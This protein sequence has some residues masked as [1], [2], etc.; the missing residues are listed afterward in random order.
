[1]EALEI[2]QIIRREIRAMWARTAVEALIQDVRLSLRIL[3]KHPG[4]TATVLSTAALGISCTTTIFTF[5]D[6]LLLRALPVRQPQQLVAIGTPGRNLNLNPT[7]FSQPFYRYLKGSS[8]TFSDLAATSIAVSSGVT[9]ENE[10]VTERIRIELVSGNYFQVLGIQPAMGRFFQPAEDATPNANPVVVVSHSFWEKHFGSSPQA[11]GRTLSL[12]GH[13]FTIVG[14]SGPRFFGTRPGF[15]P[16]AWA[17][18]MMVGQLGSARIR[19]DQ[20][21]QNYV[22]LF[23]RLPEKM[24]LESADAA[25]NSAFQQWLDSQQ[26]VR[27]QDSNSTLPA[28]AL[29]PMPRGLSLL[30]GQ[31]SE[32]LVI[33]MSS[34]VLL[35]L[36]SCAN[37]ATLLLAHATSRSREIAVRLS[38]GAGR[39]RI[40]RQM[41]TESIL[42]SILGG[43][44][45]WVASV[46]LGRTLLAF[47][48]GKV[49][50]LEFSPN[51]TIFLFAMLISGVNGALFGTAPA[52]LASRTDLMSA[53][54][55]DISTSISPARRLSLRT[56]LSTVQVALS[57]MLI[58]TAFLFDR[59]LHNLRGTEMGFRQ[60]GLLL[61]SLDP[62]RNGY[63]SERLLNFYDQV[64][65]GVREQ[66]GVVDVALASH[67]TLSGVL[68]AG[69]RFMNTAVHAQGQKAMPGEDLTTYFNTV[70]PG[71]FRTIGL[72]LLQGRDFEAFDRV[73]ADKVAVINEA[74]AE[75]WFL[76]D[77]PIGKR[78]GLGATGATDIEVIGV[79]KDAKYLNVREGAL[80]IVYRPLAQEPS[81][82]MTLHVRTTG[83]ARPFAPYIRRAV[84]AVDK[85]VPLFN[86]QTI[87]E[88]VDESLMQ[89][90]LVSTLATMLGFL[91]TVLAAIG[92]Y[93]MINYSV[94]QQ[95]RE[96]G[97]R[98]A[99][100]ATP[101]NVARLFVRK[102][103]TVASVGIVLGIPL[104]LIAARAFSGFLYKLSPAD[105]GTVVAATA[106]LFGVSA[107]AALIPSLRAATVDPLNA[108]RQE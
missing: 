29:T 38:I 40:V 49:E 27:P 91:G 57:L 33:L 59:T 42:V 62:A 41:L 96:I 46:Y 54:K 65:Q 102:A 56:V 88:R 77:N 8:A 18:L 50:L 3:K 69:T 60:T 68:P 20:P 17:P 78:I 79:V 35:L 25:A 94:V 103:L 9:L 89:E 70:T 5:V 108:L 53:I 10:S 101:S 31:Y 22:E 67:G 13:P 14:V 4:F 100:G 44:L 97:T 21:D 43:V 61:A 83:N 28:L 99:L 1:L 84:Q 106:I 23:A 87:E 37:V 63:T 58:V 51:A 16:D 72:R 55:T 11:V 90:R 30:R 80:R 82:P 107:I 95:T 74:A 66:P 19:P 105:P 26:G 93:G 34:V 81:S 6:A 86:V 45:G 98:M 48:P 85:Q 12:N 71:Y 76:G 39:S 104:S 75:Y 2:E 15:G 24:P 47:L 32:P 36:I 92:L 52:I 7:Y 73:G 64:R